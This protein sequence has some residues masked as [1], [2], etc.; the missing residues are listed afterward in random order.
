MQ[1]LGRFLLTKVYVFNVSMPTNTRRSNR[2]KAVTDNATAVMDITV[3]TML[4]TRRHGLRFILS[5][6]Q[7]DSGCDVEF[8]TTLR[9]FPKLKPCLSLER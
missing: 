6:P 8:A 3:D 2:I 4:L 5:L 1:S 9:D 7:P